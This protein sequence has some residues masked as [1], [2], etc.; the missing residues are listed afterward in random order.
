MGATTAEAMFCVRDW[1]V[2][3]PLTTGVCCR[4]HLCWLALDRLP[5]SSIAMLTE[6]SLFEA[7]ATDVARI[8]DV[9]LERRHTKI[10]TSGCVPLSVGH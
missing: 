4:S 8:K 1:L 9:V 6:S 3:N 2:W 5:L 10:D 7:V